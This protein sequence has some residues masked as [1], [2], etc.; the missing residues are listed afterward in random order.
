MDSSNFKIT[1][2]LSKIKFFIETNKVLIF[3]RTKLFS[4]HKTKIISE[5]QVQTELDKKLVYSLSKTKIPSLRQIKHINRVLSQ[6]E[7]LVMRLSFFVFI[8]SLTILGARTYISHL[9]I[10][11]AHGGEYIEGVLGAPKYI[12]PLYSSFS[13]VDG[14]I[15]SLVFSS[16]FKRDENGHLV[17]DLAESYDVSQ[18]NKIYT[19]KIKSEVKWH[20]NNQLK[21]DDILFTFNAIKDGRYNSPLKASF[22][23]VEVDKIDDVTIRFVLVEPY[24]AFLDL[25]TFGVLPQD[26]WS[27]IPPT[28]AGLADLNL[29]PIGSGSYKFKSLVKDKNGNIKAYTLVVN[30]DYYGKIPFIDTLVFRPFVNPEEAVRSLNEDNID[31]ISYLSKYFEKDLVARDSLNLYKINLPQLTA[32][33]FNKEKNKLLTDKKIRQALAFAIDKNNI[34]KDILKE[35]ARIIDGPILPDS[36]AYNTEN[37]KYKFSQEEAKTLLHDIKWEEVSISE[38][39][40]VKAEEEVN[41]EDE[42]IRK[43]AE[44]IVLMGAGTWRKKDDQFLIVNLTTVESEENLQ[45]IRAIKGY[46]ENIG[47]KTQIEIIPTNKIQTDILRPRNF[48]ALFYGQIVGADP[49]SYAFWHS[50]QI[51][52]S[53]LNIANY[54]NKEVDALLEDARVINDTEQRKEKYLKFQDIITEE[55]PAIFLYSPVY[56]YVQDKKIKGFNIKNILVPHDRFNNIDDW[57]IKTDK[58]IIW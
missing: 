26:I 1:T 13:D 42:K 22:V 33:F 57:Y 44:Q 53:G 40:L 7:R 41:S 56:T 35:D 32:I 51:K 9:Q 19:F 11:P 30:E 8:I 27:Q 3:F 58:K 45:I 29:K 48:Q 55:L 20:N 49:D 4:R 24:A 28:S 38:D 21:A 14:D 6:K 5:T 50:S 17:N 52:E 46:W 47:V 36:F 25:L 2:L 12:N 10:I 43:N 37:K 54:S 16:L 31:G 15:T 34:I 39:D 18:D 23:G